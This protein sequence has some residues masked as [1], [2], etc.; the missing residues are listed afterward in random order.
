MNAPIG[1]DKK[2]KYWFHISSNRNSK[3]LAKF[4]PENKLENKKGKYGLT[5]TQVAQK[6]SLIIYL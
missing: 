1:K 5:P 4:A 3:H 6:H 2:N